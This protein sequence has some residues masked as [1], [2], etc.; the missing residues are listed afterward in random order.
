MTDSIWVV[1]NAGGNS[2]GKNEQADAFNAAACFRLTQQRVHDQADI[3]AIGPYKR[4][5]QLRNGDRLAILQGGGVKQWRNRY[6]AGEFVACGRVSE[7]ARDFQAGDGNC[8]SVLHNLTLKYYPPKNP[9]NKLA[10]II[11]Y[12]VKRAKDKLLKEKIILRSGLP[13]RPMPSQKYI[14]IT[15]EDPGYRILDEWWK[16]NYKD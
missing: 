3:L 4:A 14:E 11:F 7:E 15:P 16:T 8:Y 13:L 2:R 10:G 1:V 9:K 6:G 5:K 12:S